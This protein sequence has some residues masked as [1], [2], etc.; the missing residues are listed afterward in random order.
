MESVFWA[1]D[2]AVPFHPEN[3]RA[4]A[5]DAFDETILMEP[6]AGVTARSLGD[7]Q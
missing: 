4:A 3:N 7:A 1:I 5:Q 6:A 2:E